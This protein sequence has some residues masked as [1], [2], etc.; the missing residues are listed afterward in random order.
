MG[1]WSVKEKI[2]LPPE[3]SLETVAIRERDRTQ[4]QLL[5]DKWGFIA[6]KHSGG[7]VSGWK[8]TKRGH[9]G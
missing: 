8:I 2:N 6:K 3:P 9:Q 1:R 7:C 4:V 5:K